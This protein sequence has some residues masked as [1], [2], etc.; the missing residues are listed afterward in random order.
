MT[1]EEAIRQHID[2]LRFADRYEESGKLMLTVDQI[3]VVSPALTIRRGLDEEDIA[4]L[5]SFLAALEDTAAS[6][7][8][9][10]APLSVPSGLPVRP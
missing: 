10:I 8:D 4:E 3:D 2:P 7:S 5:I 6:Y 1:S 9:R